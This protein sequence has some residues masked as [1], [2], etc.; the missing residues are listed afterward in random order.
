MQEHGP[1]QDDGCLVQ[2]DDGPVQDDLLAQQDDG[3]RVPRRD[4]PI[5]FEFL[6]CTIYDDEATKGRRQD[7]PPVPKPHEIVN[8][9]QNGLKKKDSMIVSFRGISQAVIPELNL[10]CIVVANTGEHTNA[11]M[12]HTFLG[13]RF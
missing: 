11:P 2:H 6:R 12:M 9:F 7:P 10:E 5:K 3:P 1:L 8:M 13:C 4:A